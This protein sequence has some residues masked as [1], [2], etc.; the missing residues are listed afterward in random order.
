M[1][2]SLPVAV[3]VFVCALPAALGAQVTRSVSVGA[4]GG[5]SLPV[6]DLGE[7]AQSG[8]SVAG[9]MFL[10]PAGR[11]RLL[12]RGDVT[13]DRW[14]AKPAPGN[15][16]Q[17]ANFTGMGFVANA[18]ASAGTAKSSRRPYLLA[19]AGFF[20]TNLAGKGS[21]AGFTSESSDMGIQVGGGMTFALSGMSTFLEA[22][23]VNVFRSPTSW[24]YVPITFGVR[25]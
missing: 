15:N 5:L 2:R 11:E 16:V 10:K 14:S 13:Y 1:T 8:Y 12:F 17:D 21:G 9:H 4:S 23:Y 25:F 7:T 22:K 20:R 18:I 19:G 3:L 6:S 24:T